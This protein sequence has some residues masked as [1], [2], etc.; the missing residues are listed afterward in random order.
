MY[1]RRKKPQIRKIISHL[2]Y[3]HSPV[4]TAGTSAAFARCA[5]CK[6]KKKMLVIRASFHLP[7]LQ[8]VVGWPGPPAALKPQKIKK[9][10]RYC[11]RACCTPPTHPPRPIGGDRI[12]YGLLGSSTTE[13]A[14]A[15]RSPLLR[16]MSGVPTPVC[17]FFVWTSIYIC[18]SPDSA[19]TYRQPYGSC[20][21]HRHRRAK[22]RSCPNH[23]PQ[24]HR[25]SP[26]RSC[27]GLDPPF[28]QW[29][30]VLPCHLI[31]SL[32]TRT[33]TIHAA[34]QTGRHLI[35][36][37]KHILATGITS[38]IGAYGAARTHV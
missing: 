15:D 7:D 18:A 37:G 29:F 33:A 1:I 31:I 11:I 9:S 22:N 10:R 8:L 12:Q 17:W 28:S 4:F 19:P 6:P 16:A 36:L 25:P 24:R 3:C 34:L 23:Q 2:S 32:T 20:H 13:P 27:P 38:G 21:H 35:A 26:P 14:T 5:I 30:S